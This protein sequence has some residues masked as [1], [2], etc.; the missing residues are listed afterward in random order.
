MHPTLMFLVAPVVCIA[1]APPPA[2]AAPHISFEATHFDFGK[3]P[4]E[5]KVTHRF[6]VTNTGK[7][8]LNIT[9]LNPS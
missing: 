6:K 1:Q 8:P 3:I 7:A 9:R 4:G 2:P 5:A